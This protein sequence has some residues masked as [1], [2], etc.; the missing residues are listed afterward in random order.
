MRISDALRVRD[1]IANNPNIKVNN[2]SPIVADDMALYPYISYKRVG[3]E[4]DAW[5]RANGVAKVT[6]ELAVWSDDY[7]ESLRVADQVMDVLS[8]E[9]GIYIQ[10]CLEGYENGAFYQDITITVE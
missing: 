4:F 7:D 1:I 2:V 10:N 8:A 5:K 3:A 9:Q 6:M